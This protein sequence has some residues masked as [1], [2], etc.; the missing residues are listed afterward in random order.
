MCFVKLCLKALEVIGISSKAREIISYCHLLPLDYPYQLHLF[1]IFPNTLFQALDAAA[2]AVKGAFDE[3]Q[4]RLSDARN[5]VIRE[6]ENC[7]RKMT[8]KCDNCK[9][10]KCAQAERNCKGFLDAAGKWIGGVVNAAGESNLV[11]AIKI[12]FTYITHS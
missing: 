4:R 10:L 3:A 12:V 2:K 8:L 1:H 9:K 5:A 11:C 7:K 6:K